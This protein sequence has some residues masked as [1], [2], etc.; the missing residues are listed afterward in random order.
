MQPT[1][2]IRSVLGACYLEGMD[3]LVPYLL[4]FCLAPLVAASVCLVVVRVRR[5]DERSEDR[6]AAAVWWLGVSSAALAL[7]GPIVLFWVRYRV[8]EDDGKTSAWFFVRAFSA[9]AVAAALP[10][11]WALVGLGFSRPKSLRVSRLGFGLLALAWSCQ[12]WLTAQYMHEL[13]LPPQ[14]REPDWARV[15][16]K[17][18]YRSGRLVK[19]WLPTTIGHHELKHLT[20]RVATLEEL[21]YPFAP[22]ARPEARGIVG[23]ADF[24]QR[25]KNLRRLMI[26]QESHRRVT[27]LE[28]LPPTVESLDISGGLVDWRFLGTLPPRLKELTLRQCRLHGK[29][30]ASDIARLTELETVTLE[31]FDYDGS[32]LVDF[33]VLP[34][35]RK[36]DLGPTRVPP[37]DV[38]AL[39]LKAPHVKVLRHPDLAP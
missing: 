2:G 16:V 33:G 14:L 36:F 10:A 25:Q 1:S 19:L 5:A 22:S 28:Y 4:V 26:R 34:K 12:G 30:E 17:A 24:L 39:R 35:L 15:R 27:S 21:F 38:E 3:E 20:D 23:G 18:E 8:A 31:C 37:K 13:S 9:L 32:G 11:L 7:A 6:R 29:P